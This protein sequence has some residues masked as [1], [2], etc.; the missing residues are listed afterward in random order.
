MGGR[1]QA[2]ITDALYFLLIVSALCVV[3]FVISMS[4]GNTVTDQIKRQYGSEYAASAFKTIFNTSTPRVEGQALEDTLEVDYL[5]A[6]IKEDFADAVDEKLTKTAG[7]L[8]NTIV[9]IMEPVQDNYDYVFYI[10]NFGSANTS[11]V[12]GGY[13]FDPD[14]PGAVAGSDAGLVFLLF[15]LHN[16]VQ[17]P[18]DGKS[19]SSDQIVFLC[20]PESGLA[21]VHKVEGLL[22][23]VGSVSKSESWIRLVSL[24]SGSSTG[25]LKAAQVNLAMWVSTNVNKQDL[26]D[27]RCTAAWKRSGKE[28]EIMEDNFCQ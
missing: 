17:V 6:I 25:N 15:S 23:N 1:G 10:Y 22:S 19:F 2:A 13:V 27:L 5:L 14:S 7:V 28:W 16:A 9:G 21:N 12:S 26:C 4:Y 24:E 18:V 3:L 8:A 20:N 11:S